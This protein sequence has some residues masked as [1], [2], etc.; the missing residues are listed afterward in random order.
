MSSTPSLKSATAP[1]PALRL[2]FVALTDAAPLAAAQELGLFAHHGLRVR[3]SREVGWATVRDKV[4]FGELDGAAAP[5]PMLWAA[6]LGLGCAAANVC[7]S[8]VLNL[9][10]NA[11][12]LSERL[13]A[14][15]IR[16]IEALRTEALR[17][18]GEN[19]LTFG[20]VFP[21]SS[22]HLLLRQWLQAAR[23]DPDRDVRIAIV[24][25]AQM[26]RNLVAG[27][28]DGYCAG[29]P[30]NT[31]AVQQGEGWCPA[32]SAQ[33][34][35]GH[36]EKVLM[37]RTDFV[38]ARV[39]EHTA[40]IAALSQAAAWCDLPK[41]RAPLAEM[42]SSPLYLNL[43]A[44]VIAPAL[45]GHFDCGHDRHETAPDFH[46]FHAG[47]TNNPGIER[48]QSLQNDLVAAGL[49]PAALAHPDLPRQLFR[50]DTYQQAI[51]Q[52]HH[53]ETPSTTLPGGTLVLA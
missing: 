15:G 47:G 48:A 18:R 53:Y 46:V 8:F 39:A 29:E 21:F 33:L 35:P 31:L 1:R 50:P 2:G 6:Q 14:T 7:T 34:S 26:F 3:L 43:P 11:I 45:R 19:K 13:W 38:H 51:A 44:K 42:L 5:A 28:L 4:I 20:V 41:H 23:L 12:T 9:H 37:M 32:W 16:D 10:G 40:L 27:T 30:W 52:L 17:R 36:L 24:P 22:H 49:L 25:P